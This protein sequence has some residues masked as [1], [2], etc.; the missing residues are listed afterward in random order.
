MAAST[1]RSDDGASL[2]DASSVVLDQG[3]RPQKEDPLT[4]LPHGWDGGGGVPPLHDGPTPPAGVE[5]VAKDFDEALSVRFKNVHVKA[6][7]VD[8]AGWAAE[9]SL[10]EE[11]E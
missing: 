10:L 7:T 6:D 9:D 11:D 1:L 8:P 4:A 2:V 3:W 5:D